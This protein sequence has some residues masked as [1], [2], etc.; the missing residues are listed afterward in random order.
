MGGVSS[1]SSSSF[2]LEKSNFF[3]GYQEKMLG[4]TKLCYVT[5]KCL[6]EIFFGNRTERDF[7]LKI[8]SLA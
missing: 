4:V 3:G 6:S 5:R 2:Y 8:G 1:S 7:L